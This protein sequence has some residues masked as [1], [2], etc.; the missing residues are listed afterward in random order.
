M[1]KAGG[2]QG[3]YGYAVAVVDDPDGG[4]LATFPDVPGAI[5][6]GADE[7]EA[8]AQARIALAVTLF[9]Y[10]TMD[11]RLP[12]AR[13]RVGRKVAPHATDVLKIAVVEAWLASG[14]SKSEFARLLGV[15]EK[16]A[17]RILDADA[18]T[19][20]DRLEQALAALGRKLHIAVEA[21]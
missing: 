9:G 4:V 3:Y 1:S 20:A 14:L 15:D 21:A 2:M 13:K 19:K 5:A 6:H 7:E 18:A 16:E 11:Q 12:R 8:I 17:R 10:L